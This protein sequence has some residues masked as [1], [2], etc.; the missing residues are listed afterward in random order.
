MIDTY[1]DWCVACK[2]LDEQTFS[3]PEVRAVLKT[4]VLVKLDFTRRNDKSKA[5]RKSLNIIGMP[6]II[7]LSPDGKELKRFSGFKTKNEFLKVL[8]SL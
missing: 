8:N 1:A 5:L 3:D 4:Y 2:E 7:F 6:T